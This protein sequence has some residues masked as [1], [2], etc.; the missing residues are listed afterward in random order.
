VQKFYRSASAEIQSLIAEKVS[1]SRK[2]SVVKEPEPVLDI[3]EKNQDYRSLKNEQAPRNR[4]YSKAELIKL[5]FN[6]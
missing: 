1:T 6:P 5:T 2:S 4:L 3:S